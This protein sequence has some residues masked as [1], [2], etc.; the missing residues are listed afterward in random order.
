MAFPFKLGRGLDD[1]GVNASTVTLTSQAGVLMP[2][3]EKRRVMSEGSE[4]G[5]AKGGK[6]SGVTSNGD[7]NSSEGAK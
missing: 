6:D 4:G 3:E 2:T 7:N 1:E 5:I